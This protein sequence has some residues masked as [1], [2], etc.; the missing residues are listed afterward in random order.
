[1]P[2]PDEWMRRL[3]TLPLM[4]QPGE[5][6]M[7]NTGSDVLG[8]LIARAAGQPLETFLRERIFEPLGMRDTGF[9]VPADTLDRLATSYEADAETGAPRLY[10]A[11]ENGQ[12][13]SPPAF[14]S[15]AGGL[16]STVDD[17]LAFG[18]MLLD[19]GKY[20]SERML[21]RPTVE[22]MTTDQL[23]REQRADATDFLGANRSWGFGLSIVTQ[24]DDVSAV[25]GRFG[26]E[27]GLGTSWTEA[28]EQLEQAELFWLSTVRPDG[29]PH[30]TP[31]IAVWLDGAL[32]LC[33]GANER[34]ARNLAHN[35]HCILTTG[36]NTLNE[37]GLDLVVEGD[38][39]RVTDD[40]KLR[41]IAGRYE[42]KY[43]PDWHFDVDNGAFHGQEDNVALVFEVVPATAF[44]FGK[45]KVFSQTRWQFQA[46][47][48]KDSVA[49]RVRPVVRTRCTE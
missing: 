13:S 28:T 4:H 19:K 44:G 22:A 25:P 40:A 17:F 46:R 26:W 45:G 1:M 38:A 7:Y 21:S 48:R 5:Q 41:R 33:T 12:W 24:R 35:P 31:L 2:A 10:D 36:R 27:G 9:S 3:G 20:G 30:V 6:W 34:K 8:V 49:S 32:Y 37:D 14:P 18:Q 15:G 47:A 42:A 16:V 11:A 39:V 23:T 29:R 43:G